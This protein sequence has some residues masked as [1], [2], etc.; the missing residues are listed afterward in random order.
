MGIMGDFVVWFI[1]DS[2]RTTRRFGDYLTCRFAPTTRKL[3]AYAV[4]CE[5]HSTDTTMIIYHPYFAPF[6]KPSRRPREFPDAQVV[7]LDYSAGMLGEAFR[8]VGA[9][10]GSSRGIAGGDRSGG[11]TYRIRPDRAPAVEEIDCA[12]VGADLASSDQCVARRRLD[13]ADSAHE[14]RAWTPWRV[15][16]SSGFTVDDPDGNVGIIQL[17]QKNFWVT[18]AFRFTD[19]EIERE[20]I[21]KLMSDDNGKS[22]AE[23]RCAVDDARTFT[24]SLENPTD[25]ASIPRFMRWFENSYGAHTLAAIIHDELI[26]NEPNGG[27]LG[28]DTLSDQFF[29][30][31]MRVA[32][33]PWLKRWIM[34]A[35]VALRSRFAAGGTRR[36]SVIVWLLLAALGIASF[37]SA[38]GSWLFGWGQLVEPWLL[39]L[40]AA[41]LPFASSVLWGR[42]FGAS[43]VAAGAAL[44]ILPAALFA[45]FGYGAYQLLERGARKLGLS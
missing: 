7:G 22:E 21:A 9:I 31:M 40:F 34:W 27:L 3:S 14:V 17:D 41:T 42:Q 44:W 20:L 5:A 26:V 24:P 8:R 16:T 28:S 12:H 39:M 35:A 25:M 23:A 32:G 15:A 2:T 43:L 6:G 10:K 29:R 4:W 18:N 1:D 11:G 36:L 38:T 37:V 19:E 30:E 13:M 45:M 33:V